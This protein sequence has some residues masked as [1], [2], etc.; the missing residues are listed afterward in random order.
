MFII[1]KYLR[2]VVVVFIIQF[3]SLVSQVSAQ[4]PCDQ[5]VFNITQ[6]PYA[7]QAGVVVIQVNQAPPLESNKTYY[8]DTDPGDVLNSDYVNGDQITGAIFHIAVNQGQTLSP[9]TI[10]LK[11]ATGASNP[12]LCNFGQIYYES[13]GT[14]C[15]L[16]T[17]ETK[18]VR[19][20]TIRVGLSVVGVTDPSARICLQGQG[21]VDVGPGAPSSLTNIAFQ[22]SN[23]TWGIH[24]LTARNTSNSSYANFSC[25]TNVNIC[26]NLSDETCTEPPPPNESVGF[27]PFKI[28]ETI[29]ITNSSARSDCE[30]CLQKDGVWTAL[31]CIPT[32]PEGFTGA[33]LKIAI[34]IGGG[35]ALLLMIYGAFLMAT[36][37]G[38]PETAQKG[39]QVFGGAIMGLLFI[40]FSVVLL[41]IIGIE[42]LKIPGL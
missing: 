25:T 37:A 1:I 2:V 31:G 5:F 38:N 9:G 18:Y 30:D 15:T 16:T 34:G 27:Q 35:L 23:L 33:F 26:E 10:Y 20:D 3:S 14:T 12:I 4:S 17:N 40:I 21:C 13:L 39:K 8:I 42:I 32:S 24:A 29:S 11:E 36:S 28:C 41:R 22:T 19:G 7:N 6:K